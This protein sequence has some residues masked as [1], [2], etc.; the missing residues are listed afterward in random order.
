MEPLDSMHGCFFA[1]IGTLFFL[2][3]VSVGLNWFFGM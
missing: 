1:V 3:L 2:F